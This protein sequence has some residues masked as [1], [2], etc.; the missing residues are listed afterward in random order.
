MTYSRFWYKD[1]GFEEEVKFVYE[2]DDEE[3]EEEEEED[4]DPLYKQLTKTARFA[5]PD[6]LDEEETDG[7]LLSD[8]E[9]ELEKMVSTH[10]RHVPLKHEILTYAMYEGEVPWA[11]RRRTTGGSS[12]AEK[13]V[14]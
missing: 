14:F 5:V 8:E 4:P 1:Q 3:E 10:R 6:D 13:R 12:K 11:T 7:S 9:A 2:D